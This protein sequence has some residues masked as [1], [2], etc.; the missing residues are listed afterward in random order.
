MEKEKLN[1]VG[2]VIKHKALGRGTWVVAKTKMTGGGTGHGPHDIYPDG[3]QISCLPI[4][5]NDAIT[6]REPKRLF[7]SGCFSD[8]IDYVEPVRRVKLVTTIAVANAKPVRPYRGPVE[9]EDDKR[10]TLTFKLYPKAI[11]PEQIAKLES[12]K[13]F[14]RI[15][16]MWAERATANLGKLLADGQMNWQHSLQWNCDDAM[17]DEEMMRWLNAMW[18]TIQKITTDVEIRAYIN[19]IDKQLIR[20]LINASTGM[21]SRST[22]VVTNLMRDCQMQAWGKLRDSLENNF[23]LVTTDILNERQ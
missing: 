23:E 16:N 5:D 13:T 2:D 18:E 4:D 3:H 6:M 10:I 22:S 15:Y 12:V 1:K 20:H 7:Q 8:K 11:A 19:R 9:V 14:L 21:S 17:F